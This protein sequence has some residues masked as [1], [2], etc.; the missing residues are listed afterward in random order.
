LIKNIDRELL[1]EEVQDIL[2]EVSFNNQSIVPYTV[3]LKLLFEAESANLHASAVVF[4]LFPPPI[5]ALN[6][7][8]QDTIMQIREDPSRKIRIW[9]ISQIH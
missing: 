8:A 4:Y 6:T 1:N 7:Y 2:L 5:P 3:F 9:E